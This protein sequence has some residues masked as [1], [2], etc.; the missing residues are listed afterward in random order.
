MSVALELDDSW[1]NQIYTHNNAHWSLGTKEIVLKDNAELLD[2]WKWNNNLQT[3]TSFGCTLDSNAKL[4]SLDSTIAKEETWKYNV[5]QMTFENTDSSK[6][7]TKSECRAIYNHSS[8]MDEDEGKLV[9]Q[10]KEA[11]VKEAQQF[12]FL[13]ALFSRHPDNSWL[14]TDHNQCFPTHPSNQQPYLS[15][16]CVPCVLID[17]SSGSLLCFCPSSITDTKTSTKE[18]PFRSMLSL[19]NHILHMKSLPLVS[20]MSLEDDLYLYPLFVDWT[21]KFLYV[22]DVKSHSFQ[23]FADCFLDTDNGTV[24]LNPKAFDVH[25]SVPELHVL[26]WVP[27]LDTSSLA[28]IKSMDSFPEPEKELVTTKEIRFLEAASAPVI[29][30]AETSFFFYFGLVTVALLTLF[31][32]WRVYRHYFPSPSRGAIGSTPNP[33]PVSGGDKTPKREKSVL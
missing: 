11:T 7:L 24:K 21:R 16:D 8:S 26:V 6:I 5:Q 18:F 1:W 23:V 12:V 32:S 14:I 9:V 31:V 3:V 33:L 30:A 17:S 10:K 15:A 22:L 2:E 4:V 19:S 28:V 20:I 27:L 13:P 25:D 29:I